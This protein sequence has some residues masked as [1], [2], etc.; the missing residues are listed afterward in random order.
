M[1]PIIKE[2][3]YFTRLELEQKRKI[4]REKQQRHAEEEKKKI[5]ELHYMRCPKCGMELSE[6][7]H[8]SVK[9]DKC[10]TCN[11]I[12]LDAGELETISRLDQSVML[13]VFNFL[14]K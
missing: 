8:K 10:Y 1:V 2:E 9:I 14:K 6:I 3:E 4:E 12:W 13:N 11:G 7:D 5:K